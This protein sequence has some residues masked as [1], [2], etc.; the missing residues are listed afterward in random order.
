MTDLRSAAK[1][2]LEALETDA[3][4]LNAVNNAASFLRAALEQPEQEVKGCDHCNHPLYAAI[5]CR[6]C[7]RVTE[8]EPEQ[9]PVATVAMDVSG[10]H[11]SWNGK[12][13]GQKPDTKIAMLLK[14]LPVGTKLYT[15]PPRREQRMREQAEPV[16]WRTFDGEGGYDYRT[17]DDNENYRDE[18]DRRNP[19]HKR[20]VEPLYTHPPR[21]EWRGL[22][23]EERRDIRE[24]KKIQEELGPV[25]A[26]MML[27]L[28]LAIEAALQE[29]NA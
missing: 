15:H 29:R 4:S 24:W 5:K 28:Y 12:Y 2:A 11:L 9:E 22:T 16:A 21:R 27:Y 26:P 25:W 6:V 10:A 1:Q 17:Y 19:N 23:D 20:W 14:D 3:V 7:G 8:P 18:W 13:L